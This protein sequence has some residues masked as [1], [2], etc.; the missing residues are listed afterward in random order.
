[1]RVFIFFVFED[2]CLCF[3]S[4]ISSENVKK[5]V[6]EKHKLTINIARKHPKKKLAICLD[7]LQ[8]HGLAET[9]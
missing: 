5:F 2:Q 4:V 6:N 7:N 8:N 3:A 1:M 9:S